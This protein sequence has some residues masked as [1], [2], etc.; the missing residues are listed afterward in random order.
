MDFWTIHDAG[1][2]FTGRYISLIQSVGMWG[3]IVKILFNLEI[4][5]M[6]KWLIALICVNIVLD[7]IVGY[8][9]K[10]SGLLEYSSH[11]SSKKQYANPYMVEMKKTIEGIAE[12]VGSENH[13][14]EL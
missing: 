14:T 12:K 9:Y 2:G 4:S 11:Y 3:V 7:T 5:Q 13:F 10:K 1:A 6:G 8:F